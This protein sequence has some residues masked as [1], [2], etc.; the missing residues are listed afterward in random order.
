[1][2]GIHRLNPH[3]QSWRAVEEWANARLAEERELLESENRPLRLVKAH[4]ARI[5]LLLE[6][7]ELPHREAKTP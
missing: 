5:S 2:S 7:L 1:M 3:E 4:R 6:L